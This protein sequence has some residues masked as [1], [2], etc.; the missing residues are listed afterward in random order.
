MLRLQTKLER[1]I[2]IN[3]EFLMT[4][5]RLW[6]VFLQCKQAIESTPQKRIE[7]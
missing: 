5:L 3:H 2:D 1:K 6:I 7:I 4:R